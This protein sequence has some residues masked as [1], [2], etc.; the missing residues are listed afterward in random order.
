MWGYFGQLCHEEAIAVTAVRRQ[1]SRLGT[2]QPWSWDLREGCPGPAEPKKLEGHDGS[3][4]LEMAPPSEYLQQVSSPA[5]GIPAAP[6]LLPHV[7]LASR[8]CP[9]VRLHLEHM[10]GAWRRTLGS[11]LALQLHISPPY[12]RVTSLQSVE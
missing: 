9:S 2:D 11:H 8:P 1:L 12:N 7:G 3:G 10:A 6:S 5:T 4:R